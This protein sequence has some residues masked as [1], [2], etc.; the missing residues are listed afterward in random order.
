M[1][2]GENRVLWNNKIVAIAPALAGGARE[3]APTLAKP[4]FV[5]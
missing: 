3:I 5:G 4:T 2:I 1:I